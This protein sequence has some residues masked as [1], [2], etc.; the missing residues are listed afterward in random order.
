MLR[1][2][3]KSRHGVWRDLLRG[4]AGTWE[5]SCEAAILFETSWRANFNS[6][7]VHTFQNCSPLFDTNIYTTPQ[8]RVISTI[9][10]HTTQL[11]ATH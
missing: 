6:E 7:H 1:W 3:R 2:A 11:A 9:H 8:V 5:F 4:C 10:K